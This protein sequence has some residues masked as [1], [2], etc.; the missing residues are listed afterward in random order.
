MNNFTGIGRLCAEPEV[1]TTNSG[2]SVV[3]VTVACDH[4]G[5]T[6]FIPCV[7]WEKNAETLRKYCNKGSRIGFSGVLTSRKYQMKDGQ[8]RT[9]YEVVITNLELIETRKNEVKS[10][11]WQDVPQDDLPF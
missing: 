1:R 4:I 6:Q 3:S 5:K 10:D 7:F 2:K 11:Q 8:S 9:A